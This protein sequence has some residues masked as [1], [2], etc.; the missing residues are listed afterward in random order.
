MSLTAAGECIHSH[1]KV[2]GFIKPKVEPKEQLAKAF[3]PKPV[4]QE[5]LDRIARRHA[6]SGT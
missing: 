5:Q 2:K 6:N 1:F 3:E 4:T